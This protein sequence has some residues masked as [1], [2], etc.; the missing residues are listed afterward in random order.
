M[1]HRC[2]RVS[3][4]VVLCKT[5]FTTSVTNLDL[6]INFLFKC[7]LLMLQIPCDGGTLTLK[8]RI[9]IF[10]FMHVFTTN[11]INFAHDIY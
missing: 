4:G 8:Y 2:K 10:T 7:L 5:C 11:I 3:K 1:L 6:S 9:N